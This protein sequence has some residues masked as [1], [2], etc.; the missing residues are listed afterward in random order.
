MTKGQEMDITKRITRQKEKLAAMELKKSILTGKKK[1]WL[2]YHITRK[3][4]FIGFLERIKNGGI[5]ET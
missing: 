2:R 1:W 5:D 3:K 4:A